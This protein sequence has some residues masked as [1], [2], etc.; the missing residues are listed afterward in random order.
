MIAANSASRPVPT[1]KSVPASELCVFCARRLPRL[2]LGVKNHPQ[3]CPGTS[4]PFASSDRV[5]PITPKSHQ[6]SALSLSKMNSLSTHAESTLPQPLIPL[7]FNSFRTNVYKKHGGLPSPLRPNLSTC[8]YPVT[9]PAAHAGIPTTSL[10]SCVYFIT[11]GYPGG[12]GILRHRTR[13]HRTVFLRILLTSIFNFQRLTVFHPSPLE[14]ALTQKQGG[15]PPP[16]SIRHSLR[17]NLLPRR[18]L[19]LHCLWLTDSLS[20]VGQAQSPMTRRCVLMH[21]G[22]R[23]WRVPRIST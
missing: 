15:A 6:P 9:P 12:G 10:L 1:R 13:P 8:Q 7:D 16:D 21:S 2:S 14:S 3:P 19:L 20:R 4:R 11:C 18:P 22:R 5:L 23:V 17:R